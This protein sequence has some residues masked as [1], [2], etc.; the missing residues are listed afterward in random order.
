MRFRSPSPSAT[1]R[2][3]REL[4]A[5]AGCAAGLVVALAGPL[6][7]GKTVFVKGAAAGLGI[8]PDAVTSPTFVLA[9]RYEGARPLVHVDCYR[10]ES[11]EALWSAGLAD[12][13]EPGALVLVEWGDRFPDALPKDRLEVVLERRGGTER[14]VG[15]AA[16]GPASRDAL[17]HWEAARGTRR[18]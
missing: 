10:V 8:D 16:R 2:A 17:A 1:A 12:W 9:Q 6:G 3:G 5:A 4:A 18:E 15:V 7:A 14:L 13:L 11:E